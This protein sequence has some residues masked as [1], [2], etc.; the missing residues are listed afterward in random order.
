MYM[1]MAVSINWG[2]FCG[3]PRNCVGS[4]SRPLIFGSSS[5]CMYMYACMYMYLSMHVYKHMYMYMHIYIYISM[6]AHVYRPTDR[7]IDG[8]IDSP[9]TVRV[10]LVG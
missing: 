3:C 4:I 1:H 2:L 10:M 7:Q 6:Y 9:Y 5:I 8:S